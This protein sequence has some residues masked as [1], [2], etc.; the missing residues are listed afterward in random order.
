MHTSPLVRCR[1]AMAIAAVILISP[2]S[3]R[4]QGCV[5][6]R[7]SGVCNV[8]G[9][10]GFGPS[11]DSKWEASVGYR[12]FKSDRHFVGDEEQKQREEEGSQV[13]NTSNFI[14]ANV[15]YFI[16]ERFNTTLT[17]PFVIHDRSQTYVLNG[18]RVRY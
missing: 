14:D 8:H 16:N 11:D 6:A 5:A 13:I 17:V 2:A 10:H 12:Y 1:L 18:E 9:D 4:A 7:G 15:T 3:T